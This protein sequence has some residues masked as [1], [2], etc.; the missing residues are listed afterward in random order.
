MKSKMRR[1]FTYILALL[2]LSVS[3]Q[4]VD[5]PEDPSEN[6]ADLPLG[7]IGSKAEITFSIANMMDVE[8]KVVI[9]TVDAVC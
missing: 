5:L 6:P 8:T 4:R 1:I 7:A 9:D 3:C 2:A